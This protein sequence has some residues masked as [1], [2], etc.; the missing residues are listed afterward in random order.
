MN[1]V[2][3]VASS[4]MSHYLPPAVPPASAPLASGATLPVDDVLL[5]SAG[6]GETSDYTQETIN[7]TRA[8]PQQLT[9]KADNGNEHAKA[10]LAAQA[11]AR[12]LLGADGILL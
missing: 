1:P 3:G 10:I 6:V 11:A 4:S 12:K 8:T 2:A 7:L 9:Q 5:G